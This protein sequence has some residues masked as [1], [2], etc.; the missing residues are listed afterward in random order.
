MRKLLLTLVMLPVLALG[1]LCDDIHAV[2]N[3]WHK[4][5]NAIHNR[6]SE[7]L[8]AADRKKIAKEDRVL[9]QPS[10]EVVTLC[11][12]ESGKVKALGNQLGGLLDEYAAIDDSESWDE[13]V[14][15]ID[16]MVDVLDQLTHIC[17]ENHD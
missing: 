10:R 6:H 15:V 16:K 8:S 17:D 11:R 12:R 4:L 14:R 3:R 9:I 1:N 5:A 7:N 13:D 2:A